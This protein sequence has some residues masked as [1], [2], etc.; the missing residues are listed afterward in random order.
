M[1]LLLAPEGR[2]DHHR[3]QG[4]AR[5]GTN[6]WLTA[7]HI[8]RIP[9]IDDEL[10]DGQHTGR[11]DLRQMRFDCGRHHNRHTTMRAEA[12][13]H[14]ENNSSSTD[15]GLTETPG[16]RAPLCRSISW[17]WLSRSPAQSPAAAPARSCCVPNNRSKA[18]ER[19]R[20]VDLLLLTPS[21]AQGL[22]HC[23][24]CCAPR[25]ATPAAPEGFGDAANAPEAR[26]G[27]RIRARDLPLAGAL[28]AALEPGEACEAVEASEL[29]HSLRRNMR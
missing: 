24:L 29:L 7:V 23:P 5:K 14:R 13:N 2:R 25:S 17:R 27:V 11:W 21:A 20:S 15:P 3:Q 8:Q 28:K 22:P 9:N 19:N 10:Q 6:S 1:L 16:A 4:A 26:V 18:D 12:A